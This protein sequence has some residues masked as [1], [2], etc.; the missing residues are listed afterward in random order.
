[1]NHMDMKSAAQSVVPVEIIGQRILLIRGQKVMLDR[2]LA[3]LYGV[4]S[5]VL[6]QQVKRHADRFPLDFMFQLSQKEAKNMV[7][8]SV[9]PSWQYLGGS[10]P[11]VFTQEGIAMLSS[12]LHSP[13]AIQVNIAIMRTFVQLRE[14]LSSHKELAR[15]LE[16]LEQKYDEQFKAVFDAIRE[17]MRPE[18]PESERRIGFRTK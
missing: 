11:Y 6:R 16:A 2:D 4:K 15:K 8:Q 9:I 18:L 14:W 13:R 17:I 7:S 1:M 12:V 5:T 10:L 3:Q